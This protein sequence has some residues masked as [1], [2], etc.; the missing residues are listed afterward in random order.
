M[1]Y[2]ERKESWNRNKNE[3][4]NWI[5]EKESSFYSLESEIQ[6]KLKKIIGNLGIR[7]SSSNLNENLRNLFLEKKNISGK[8]LYGEFEIGKVGMLS[9][10]KSQLSR[11]DPKS[12]IWISYDENKKIYS[13]EG[14]GKDI[15]ENFTGWIPKEMRI[16]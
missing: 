3:L 5:S 10:I 2:E 16:L 7:Q 11:K 15:P 14:K 6:L 13:L 9:F 4:R 12:W 1:S 8:E